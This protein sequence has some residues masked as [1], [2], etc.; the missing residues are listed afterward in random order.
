MNGV[1]L[2]WWR[3]EGCE[4]T[5]AYLWRW[6]NLYS[7]TDFVL[8]ALMLGCTLVV[9]LRAAYRLRALPQV[10]GIADARL[11]VRMV[12]SVALASPY[13]GLV[14]TC[15]G[16]LDVFRGVAMEKHAALMMM[17]V[18]AAA[19]LIPCAVGILVAIVAIC[20]QNY[21]C[22]RVEK[23]EMS[24]PSRPRLSRRTLAPI[25][26]AVIAAAYLSVADT[27]MLSFKSAREAVGIAVDVPRPG[28]YDGLAL[29]PFRPLV[30]LRRNDTAQ[31][32]LFLDGKKLPFAE[33]EASLRSELNGE[34]FGRVYVEADR[35]LNWVEVADAL[36]AVTAAGGNIMLLT[37]AVPRNERGAR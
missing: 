5:L 10:V 18:R 35:E 19:A 13:L 14:G 25:A 16:I 7:R 12:G 20:S 23:A 15:C 4:W 37:A 6:M 32:L 24:L 3:P 27:V 29:S 1:C 11:A 28:P 36:D 8:L 17:A 26:F 21:L 2:E 30:I 9:T 34:Q 33:L 31:M 22:R